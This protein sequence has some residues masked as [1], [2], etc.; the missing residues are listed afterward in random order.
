MLELWGMRRTPSM[1]S[2][3]NPL[4]FGMVAPDRVL[5]VGQIELNYILMLN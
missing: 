2:F 1:L 4:W 5:S 3:P